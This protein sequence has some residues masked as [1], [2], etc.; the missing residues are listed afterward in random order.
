LR[1]LAVG[2]DVTDQIELERR[3]REQE[4]MAA[5]GRLTA[6]LAHEIRNPL[7]AAKLQLEL[8]RRGVAKI[9]DEGV[10]TPIAQRA[11]IVETELGRLADLLEDFLTMARSPLLDR[12][13]FELVPVVTEVLRLQQPHA[14][15]LGAVLIEDVEV[16][17]RV[18]GDKKRI[19]QLLVNLVVN[20]LEALGVR[21]DGRV[22][23]RA[24][25]DGDVVQVDVEDNGP[26]FSETLGGDALRPFVTSKPAG[27]GL[28][29]SIVHNIVHAH[30]GTIT[31]ERAEPTGARV[32]VTLPRG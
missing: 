28:G 21:T 29:L 11:Q 4:S 31:L 5:M 27:T 15:S 14:E 26:G 16:G 18:D 20:A 10:R 22:V 7:N 13:S 17:M 8:L 3:S 12:A 1:A 6:A 24:R 19:H 23:I 2:F 30:G 9:D 32:R 25:C